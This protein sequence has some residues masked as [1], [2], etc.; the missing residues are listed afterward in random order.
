MKTLLKMLEKIDFFHILFIA[1]GILGILGT[2]ALIWGLLPFWVA[3]AAT[4][5]YA[6]LIAGISQVPLI[7]YYKAEKRAEEARK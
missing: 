6:L 3:V 7:E 4:I 1:V 2:L 5:F